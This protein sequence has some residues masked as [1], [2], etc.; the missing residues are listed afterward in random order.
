[1]AIGNLRANTEMAKQCIRHSIP[2][3]INNYD[4][5]FI[6]LFTSISILSLKRQFKAKPFDNYLTECTDQN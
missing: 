2:N 5:I 1:M 4:K 6:E 3:L